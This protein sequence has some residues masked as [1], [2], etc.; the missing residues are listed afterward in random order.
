MIVT[1]SSIPICLTLSLWEGFHWRKQLGRPL[2]RQ[3]GNFAELALSSCKALNTLSQV[4]PFWHLLAVF[5][6]QNAEPI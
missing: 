6:G 4:S 5:V 3:I 2:K 1:Y